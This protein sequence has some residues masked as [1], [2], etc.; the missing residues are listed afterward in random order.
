MLSG[1]VDVAFKPVM[2]ILVYGS[3]G[4]EIETEAL[5]DT[6]CNDT[7]VLSHELVMALH[8]P[9]VSNQQ[10]RVA[11]GQVVTCPV[12]RVEVQWGTLRRTFYASV[13]G[14]GQEAILGM[15]AF[16]GHRIEIEAE[17]GGEVQITPL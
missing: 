5:V 1:S 6:G 16:Q 17:V 7:L 9:Q 3:N 8:A 2:R 13:L 14:S 11:S 4:R 12:H 15:Q 10:I